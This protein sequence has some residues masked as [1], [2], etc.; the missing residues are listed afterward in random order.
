MLGAYL[1]LEGLS[2][3]AA[4]A[5]RRRQLGRDLRILHHFYAWRDPLPRSDPYLPAGGVL[6]V[7]WRGTVYEEIT[8]G[9]CDGMIA[10]AARRLARYGDPVLLRWGWEMNGDWFVWG[11]ARNDR[12]TAGYVAAWRRLHRIFAEQGADNVSWVWSP[13]WNSQP[14]AGWNDLRRYY[15]GDA[16]VDWVGVSGYNLGRESPQQLFGGVYAEYASRKPIIIAEVGA[17]DHGGRSKADWVTRF[18]DWV[19]AHP[20]VGAVVWFDTDTH[21][22]APEPWRV[23]TDPAA[24]AAYRAMARDRTFAG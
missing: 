13:N 9:A 6:M 21:P 12:D 24:L 4:L 2:L 20:E 1:D 11:G 10:A 5:L 17:V 22:G 3:P 16:Y 14:A 7:T 18:A 23:D 8:G 19:R 15:P